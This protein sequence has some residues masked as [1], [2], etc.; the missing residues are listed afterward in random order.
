[1][2]RGVDGL[3][4]APTEPDC[5]YHSN[6]VKPGYPIVFLDRPCE[7]YTGDMILLFNE[8]ASYSAVKHLIAR[9]YREIGF[10]SFHYGVGK[11][12]KT[13]QE[14]LDG[15]KQALS[16]AGIPINEKAVAL[17]PGIPAGQGGLRYTESYT[18]MAE[19]C[20]LPIRAVLCG[21]SLTAVGAYSYLR[22]NHVKV[23]AEVSLLTFDDDEWLKLT[24]PSISSV[25]QP[26]ESFGVLAAQRL[27]KR[28][29]GED[30]APETFRL[31]AQL[32]VRES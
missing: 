31:K 23:P 11:P 6:S 18:K 28:M 13:M 12:D 14:R 1:V 26:M 4:I 24:T 27:I 2:Y 21:N 20:K 5:G 22:D 3:I 17:I 8:Q 29:A 30:V 25:V 19:L 15:Y 9:G 16:E 32:V 7:N 10:L